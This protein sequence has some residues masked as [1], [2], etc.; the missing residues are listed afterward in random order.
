MEMYKDC[1]RGL[2]V[3]KEVGCPVS[4]VKISEGSLSIERTNENNQP[5]I[6]D[7]EFSLNE[8]RCFNS[9]TDTARIMP[10]GEPTDYPYIVRQ[11][12]GCKDTLD[13]GHTTQ[14][15]TCLERELYEANGLYPETTSKLMLYDHFYDSPGNRFNLY[16]YQSFGYEHVAS[17]FTKDQMSRHS[18]ETTERRVCKL[19][20]QLHES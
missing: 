18:S 17:S 11:N 14:I 16:A 8:P 2:L 13:K 6:Y 10:Q 19:L 3:R 4:K 5:P 7:L 12:S 1:G 20:Q 9:V 15:V